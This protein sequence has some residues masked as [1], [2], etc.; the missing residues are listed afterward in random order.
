MNKSLI[1]AL[2]IAL[3]MPCIAQAKERL[4]VG[5]IEKDGRVLLTFA[6]PFLEGKAIPLRATADNS[7]VNE[8]YTG[9]L[10]KKTASLKSY[11]TGLV[12]DVT[13][14]AT[15]GGNVLL[16]LAGKDTKI[17]GLMEFE[18]IPGTQVPH[19]STHE[20][21]NAHTIEVG[22]ANSIG[23]GPCAQANGVPVQ[24]EYTLHVN[25]P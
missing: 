4:I 17:L 25:L 3:I 13:P 7:Y 12:L 9:K 21:K 11:T 22:K 19:L 20:F 2:A 15:P 5:H 24:C 8:I 14:S 18:Q 6:V 10:G 1:P 23:F 16:T